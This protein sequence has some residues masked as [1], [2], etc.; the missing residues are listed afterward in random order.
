MKWPRR[1]IYLNLNIEMHR[2]WSPV[3]PT[4]IGY[5]PVNCNREI[6][7][8]LLK[9]ALNTGSTGDFWNSRVGWFPQAD[10]ELS[11]K[12]LPVGWSDGYFVNISW[13]QQRNFEFGCSADIC[14]PVKPVTF[15]VLASVDSHWL[16][17]WLNSS[18]CTSVKP[19]KGRKVASVWPMSTLFPDLSLFFH[20]RSFPQ[21]SK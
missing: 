13:L 15:R 7:K 8:I 17:D 3:D 19:M 9:T 16:A 18:H 11:S 2:S 5:T 6:P 12:P 1:W 14:T 10:I 21:K 20:V 4:L